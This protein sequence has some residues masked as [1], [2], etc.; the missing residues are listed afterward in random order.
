MI[1]RPRSVAALACAFAVQAAAAAGDG[2]SWYSIVA[3]D[4]ARFGH[5]SHE[6]RAL[7]DGRET[8]DVHVIILQEPEQLPVRLTE[9]TVVREDSSGRAV[10]IGEYAQVGRMWT[11]TEAAIGTG[12]ATV[13][14]QSRTDRRR[15]AVP[16]PPG[17]RFDN[18][19]GLLRGW[20]PL[21][22]PPLEFASFNLGAIAVDRV[23]IEPVRGAERDSA[24]RVAVLRKRYEGDQLRSVSRLTLD[25]DGRIVDAVQ[26]MFGTSLRLV[27]ATREEAQRRHP[28][29]SALRRALV[30]SP[31]R[32]SAAAMQGRIRYRFA[33]RDGIDF[34]L[35][36]T[37]EQR[38]AADADGVTLDICADC[39]PGL[40]T[41]AAALAA[42]LRPTPWLQSDH[43]RL[44]AIAAPVARQDL[45]GARKMELLARRVRERLPRIDFTGHFSALDA[46]DR[47]AG[48]CTESAVLLAALGRAA[49]IPARVANGLVY[50]R[51]RYHG[52]GNVFMPH[53]WVIAFVDGEWRS[54]DAALDG[55]D[56]SHI[57]VTIGDGDARSVG[58]ASQLASLLQWREMAEIR[59]RPER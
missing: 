27:P 41:D 9:R 10:S 37:S 15:I 13:T 23:R 39:G 34:E 26:P 56:A 35:P 8:V 19:E 38:A 22:M 12:E 51:E 31:F 44:R 3:D 43:P 36:Q 4:G 32:I 33:Y 49:G 57:A 59:R 18:G 20:D 50:S 2:T 55:F 1:P 24:G 54:F 42:A 52:V 28:P 25:R 6:V 5:A 21:A 58:A 40:P 46:F 53:S 7:A 30:R 47:G 14:R 16:L 17:V 11:R 45:T 29:Y 48:D